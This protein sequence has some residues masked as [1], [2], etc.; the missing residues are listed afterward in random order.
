MRCLWADMENTSICLSFLVLAMMLYVGTS[1]ATESSHWGLSA[2][3]RDGSDSEFGWTVTK[4]A[5]YRFT[6]EGVELVLCYRWGCAKTATYL[7]R[8]RHLEQI[9]KKIAACATDA[10]HEILALRNAV[11]DTEA[12]ILR[13]IGIFADDIAGNH[14]DHHKGGRMDCIDASSN[15]HAIL[16][17]LQ[18]HQSFRYWQVHKPQRDGFLKPHRSA[19]V[20]TK[21]P[22]FLEKYRARTRMGNK[23]Y[24][25]WV[26]DSWLTTF[27]HKPFV[28]EVNDWKYKLDPW[29]NSLYLGLYR[30][31]LKC[32]N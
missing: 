5:E 14:I 20:M 24:T 31:D 30:K 29:G 1:S 13:K 19:A 32:W 12:Q 17:V 26:V 6:T 11:R 22:K 21:D 23:D 2:G 25:V 27:A 9:S 15:T 4:P 16:S 8:Q 3:D 28:Y 10:E 18:K 7:W